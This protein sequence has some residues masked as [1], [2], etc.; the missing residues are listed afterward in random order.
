MMNQAINVVSYEQ[1]IDPHTFEPYIRVAMEIFPGAYQND[2]LSPEYIK[3]LLGL[4]ILAAIESARQE[5][6]TTEHTRR[7]TPKEEE[8]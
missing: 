4:D 2:N 6:V 5:W 8:K 1:P 3:G 7:N